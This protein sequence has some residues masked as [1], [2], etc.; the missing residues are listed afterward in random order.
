M[1]AHSPHSYSLASRILTRVMITRSSWAGATGRRYVGGALAVNVRVYSGATTVF[2]EV[3]TCCSSSL[4]GS[5]RGGVF[6]TIH[7]SK[8]ACKSTRL[9]GGSIT[10]PALVCGALIS[11]LTGASAVSREVLP[12]NR[13]EKNQVFIRIVAKAAYQQASRV[14]VDKT[15]AR[16]L[17]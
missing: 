8:F 16:D 2:W 10:V 15:F 1:G 13:K 9:A 6:E 3:A 7:T 11:E 14:F 4:A 17:V 12:M 5:E